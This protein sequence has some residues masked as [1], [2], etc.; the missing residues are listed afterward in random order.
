MKLSIK[1]TDLAAQGLEQMENHPKHHFDWRT[2]REIYRLLRDKHGRAGTQVHGWIAVNAAE[3]V[4]P[5][6]AAAFPDDRLPG[7]LIRYAKRILNGSIDR[8][9]WRIKML[10]EEGYMGTGIDNMVVRND[11]PAYNADYAGAAAYHALME[12]RGALRLL[13]NVEGLRRRDGMF[14]SGGMET[15][16]PT[17]DS[18]LFTDEDIAHLA[19]YSDTAGPA[20]IAFACEHEQFLVH[21][22]RL[23]VFWRWWV[24]VALPDAAGRVERYV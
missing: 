18:R 3:Y 10:E 16:D 11:L 22:E 21:P 15:A 17:E 14:V 5:I 24:E 2:R 1:I 6:F 19:A 12:A 8:K 20:A 4:F 7:R 9:S 13:D 23:R